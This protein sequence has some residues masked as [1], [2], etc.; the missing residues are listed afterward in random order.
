MGEIL[1]FSGFV[2]LGIGGLLVLFGASKEVIR[3]IKYGHWTD[4]GFITLFSGIFLILAGM[5]VH[6]ILRN[7]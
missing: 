1:F 5:F 6:V 2:I 4:L 3:A 7:S